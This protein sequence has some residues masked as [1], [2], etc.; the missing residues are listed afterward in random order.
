MSNPTRINQPF[1]LAFFLCAPPS[2]SITTLPYHAIP[3]LTVPS[4]GYAL[5]CSDPPKRDSWLDVKEPTLP[6]DMDQAEFTLPETKNLPLK[7][8]RAPKKET[9]V[10]Q[11]QFFRGKRL[12]LLV[13]GGVSIFVQQSHRVIWRKSTDSTPLLESSKPNPPL[14]QGQAISF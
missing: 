11:A 1:S 8:G 13:S 9:I 6:K 14:F 7:I 12:L 5:L 4:H 10:F 2:L 3:L